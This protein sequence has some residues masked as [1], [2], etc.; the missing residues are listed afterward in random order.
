MPPE[1]ITYSFRSD[2][3]GNISI[4]GPPGLGLLYVALGIAARQAFLE[5]KPVVVHEN[6]RPLRVVS[7]DNL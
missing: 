4:T 5:R 7:V 6:A 1:T 3:L 2:G